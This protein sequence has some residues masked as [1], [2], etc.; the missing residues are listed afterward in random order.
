LAQCNS[1][2]NSVGVL[3]TGTLGMLFGIIVMV[4]GGNLWIAIIAHGLLDASHAI[5]F[6]FK[7]ALTG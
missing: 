7:G 3:L 6:Y 4:F 1:Y 2:Q 5:L